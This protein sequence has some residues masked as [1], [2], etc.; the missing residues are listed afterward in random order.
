MTSTITKAIL[1]LVLG[2]LLIACNDG[3]ENRV[4]QGWSDNDV[5][6]LTVTDA[7]EVLE[8]RE[9]TSERHFAALIMRI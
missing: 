6:S 1:I 3:S 2:S 4:D 7:M 9:L 8:S 5:I